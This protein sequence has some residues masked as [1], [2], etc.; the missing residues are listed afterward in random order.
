M[1]RG[2]I[3]TWE[4]LQSRGFNGPSCCVL[5]EGNMEDIHH[6]FFCCPFSV[7]IFNHFAVKFKCSFPIYSSVHSFLDLWFISTAQ[8]APFRYLPL[9]IFWGI[10]LLRNHCLFESKKLSFSALISRIEGLVISFPVPIIIHKSHNAGPE[11]LKSFP[12]GFFDGAAAENIGDSGFV[13]FINDSHYFSFSMGCGRSTNTRAE[14]LALWEILRV[15]L[16]MGIPMQLIYGDS[17]VTISWINRISALDVPSLMH[18][19]NDIRYMIQLAPLVIFKH[20]FRE[21]NSLANALS[22]KSLHLD[23]GFV[24]FTETVDGLVIN[25]GNLDLF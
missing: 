4:Q 13:I 3:L 22:K 17:M 15:G 25:Q 18:W 21:H 16:L 1:I 12:C 24:S 23:M 20:T 11:P 8:S 14:L 5:C 6:L 7:S 10:W 19:C 9:F 2:K